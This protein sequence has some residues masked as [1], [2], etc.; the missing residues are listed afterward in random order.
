[1]IDRINN[2]IYDFVQ[3]D[4]SVIGGIGAV[5]EV[6]SAAKRKGTDVVVM[7]GVAPLP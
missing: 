1:M 3:P 5:M 2:N 4:A 6:F 7:P